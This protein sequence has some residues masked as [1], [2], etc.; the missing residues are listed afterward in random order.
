MGKK[1]E[2]SQG[3]TE[4]TARCAIRITYTVYASLPLAFGLSCFHNSADFSN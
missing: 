3:T 1:E 2:T 4:E